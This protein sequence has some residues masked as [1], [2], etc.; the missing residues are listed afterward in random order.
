MTTTLNG[1]CLCGAIRYTIGVPVTE[2]RA[3]HCTHCQKISGAGA[4]V[5]AIV[6]TA[7]FK[8][9]KGTPR[10]YDDTADSGRIL[11]RFFCPDC[12]S[13]LFSRRAANPEITVLKVGTLDAPVNMKIVAHI[14]TRS[15]RPWSHIDPACEQHREAPPPP[16]PAR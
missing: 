2:L 1:G 11:Q 3:C 6:P 9:E 7:G 4:S 13:S 14:W 5:N 10:R 16:P 15:A 8:L 12:G